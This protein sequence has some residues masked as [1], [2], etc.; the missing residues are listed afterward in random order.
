VGKSKKIPVVDE[1]C[2]S[3]LQNLPVSTTRSIIHKWKEHQP[4]LMRESEGTSVKRVAQ[5]PK[6]SQKELQKDLKAA[7]T[8][9][10]ENNAVHHHGLSG[11]SRQKTPL[12]K[13][14]QDE[15]CSNLATRH[16][17]K[18]IKNWEKVV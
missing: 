5:E 4:F 16:L 7:G 1:R 9:V 2:I 12:L 3:K 15:A 18:P 13:K 11:R 10:K 14:R 17:D 8:V 6:T